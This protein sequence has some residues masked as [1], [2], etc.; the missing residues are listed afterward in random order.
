MMRSLGRCTQVALVG[1]AFLLSACAT[2]DYVSDMSQPNFGSRVLPHFDA[3]A[4]P[5][6]VA[7]ANGLYSSRPLQG[8]CYLCSSSQSPMTWGAWSP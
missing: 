8:P 3:S 6:P 7:V 1:A 4:D 5:D 2:Q